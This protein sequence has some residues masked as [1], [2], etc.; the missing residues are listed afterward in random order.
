MAP[1][2][3][4]GVDL[5]TTGVDSANRVK[6]M[7]VLLFHAQ[8]LVEVVEGGQGIIGCQGEETESGLWQFPNIC[9]AHHHHHLHHPTLHPFPSPS[10][11]LLSLHHWC[12]SSSSSETTRSFVPVLDHRTGGSP[13]PRPGCPVWTLPTNSWCC[14]LLTAF[15]CTSSSALHFLPA[16]TRAFVS[17]TDSTICRFPQLH[18][19][20]LLLLPGPKRDG[21]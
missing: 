8:P 11:T 17:L 19:K 4:K 2:M 6:L 10:A 9:P 3:S 12:S 20:L 14:N 5:P 7:R 18:H 16:T 1:S 15:F 21:P 13:N